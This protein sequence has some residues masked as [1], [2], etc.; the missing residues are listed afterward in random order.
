MS[1]LNH[2]LLIIENSRRLLEQSTAPKLPLSHLY[3]N[4]R[5]VAETASQKIAGG[6]WENFTIVDYM[7]TWVLQPGFPLVQ[8]ARPN[9]SLP[10]WEVFV[11]QKLFMTS[12]T[13][14]SKAAIRWKVPLFKEEG[15]GL[16]WLEHENM[17]CKY[18]S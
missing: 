11:S 9:N 12:V 4:F 5:V 14:L 15:E 6:I 1:K 10:S 17:T 7:N 8:I 2:V 13:P 18:E 16:T 3:L